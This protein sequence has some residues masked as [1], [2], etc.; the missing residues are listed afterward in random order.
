MIPAYDAKKI[1]DALKYCAYGER[2]CDKC[3]VG[4]DCKGTTNKA[5]T[6]AI[7]WI[8]TEATKK[9][10]HWIDNWISVKDGTPDEHDS[11]FAKHPHL[12]KYMWAKESDDV[13]VYV[14]FPDG[15]GRSTEGRLR[16]GKWHTKIY[17]SLEPVVTHW[18]PLPE[19][20]KEG[21]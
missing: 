4:K 10:P 13:I 21:T 2:S 9:Q 6:L 20:P 8:E 18:M 17:P 1:I 16:D 5:M 12:N 3:P 7:E 14:R 11:L 19:P 15:S